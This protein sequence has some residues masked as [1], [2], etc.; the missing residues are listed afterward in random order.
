MIKV[1][2]LFKKKEGLSP[3]EFKNHYEQHHARL[4]D[5]VISLPGVERYVRRYLTPLRDAVSGETRS[6][7]FDVVMEVWFSNEGT[8]QSYFAGDMFDSKFL[9][10]ITEDEERLFD[11]SRMFL[12][13][14]EEH[15]SIAA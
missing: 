3:E 1:V 4:Y 14:V 9:K 13:T 12:H 6:S 8:F 7:G 11:R 10:A 2:A 5:W 15:E